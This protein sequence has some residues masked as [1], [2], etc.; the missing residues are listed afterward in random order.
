MEIPQKLTGSEQVAK[1]AGCLTAKKRRRIHVYL[2]LNGKQV[3]VWILLPLLCDKQTKILCGPHTLL[4]ACSFLQRPFYGDIPE[5]DRDHD[6][7][8]RKLTLTQIEKSLDMTK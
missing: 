8:D 2:D 4:R 1:F 5:N 7:I 6:H 3:Y